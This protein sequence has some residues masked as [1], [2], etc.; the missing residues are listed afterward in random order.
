MDN[1]LLAWKEFIKGKRNK[2][3]VQLFQL[4]LMDNLIQLHNDLKN[5]TYQ[6]GEYKNFF[7]ND[8]K[9]RHIHKATVRDRILHHAIYRILY[10][11][12]ART[13]I[14]DS[15]SCQRGKGTHKAINRFRSFG[16]QV[17]QNN[18][19]TARI[20]KCDI[21]KFFDN[22]DHRILK[23]ILAGY[24]S[25]EK[26]L[27]LLERI[28]D[29][30]NKKIPHLNPPPSAEEGGGDG[31]GLPLGNLTSQLFVNIYMNEF[32]QFMKHKIKAEHYIRY[33][34]DFVIFSEDKD[35]LGSILP[36]MAEFL[37]NTL[38]LEIHP[39]KIFLKTLASGMD[40]LGWV[41]FVDHRVLRASTKRKM[42]KKLRSFGCTQDDRIGSVSDG[43]AIQSYSGLLKWGNTFKLSKFT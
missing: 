5:L 6:H 22:I 24:I 12:F 23:D 39:K 26:I 43:S 4:N 14:A 17:S 40:Y 8:P 37:K 10:P 28:I 36:K 1:L 31:V 2:K 18:T 3:D 7:I 29:S 13:F 15:F 9:R 42:L 35:W 21:R 30:F 19:K 11:F 34:D 20:L 41:H 25:D 27:R 16:Y 38:G 33:A 32:D